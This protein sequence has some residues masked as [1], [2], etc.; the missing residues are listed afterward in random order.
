MTII[1]A[2]DSHAKRLVR[3]AGPPPSNVLRAT[4][5]FQSVRAEPGVGGA[6]SSEAETVMES[7][8]HHRFGTPAHAPPDML[9]L[10]LGGNMFTSRVSPN[11]VLPGHNTIAENAVKDIRW[12]L[13]GLT[14]YAARGS[15]VLLLSPIPR[16]RLSGVGLS[17]FRQL[18]SMLRDVARE[19]APRCIFLDAEQLLEAQRSAPE[20][21]L[22][23]LC[24]RA[25]DAMSAEQMRTAGAWFSKPL[26]RDF[27]ALGELDFS[28][29]VHLHRI[30]YETLRAAVEAVAAA[31]ALL[32][33]DHVAPPLRQ[34]K[35]SARTMSRK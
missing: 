2:G 32:P 34:R 13:G 5:H 20:S 28:D 12:L 21:W 17:A 31:L 11:V 15:T 7:I 26:P 22:L 6:K 4:V 9:V 10:S 18:S 8:F 16:A 35:T 33:I 3:A 24:G 1:T 19:F 23:P 14:A 30:H 29:G 25:E 27:P